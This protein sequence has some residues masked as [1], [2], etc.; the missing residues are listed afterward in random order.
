MQFKPVSRANVTTPMIHFYKGEAD[1]RLQKFIDDGMFNTEVV[2]SAFVDYYDE[3]QVS[4]RAIYVNIGDRD[5]FK[6]HT[7]NIDKVAK[8]IVALFND[9][10]TEI[11]L[12]LS[13]LNSD[14]DAE[15]LIT[16]LA[17]ADYEYDVEFNDNDDKRTIFYVEDV[18]GQFEDVVHR[19]LATANGVN[20]TRYL[21]DLPANICTPTELASIASNELSV[22]KNVK[23]NVLDEVKCRELGMNLLTSVSDGSDEEG[24]VIIVTYDGTDEEEALTLGL[25]GKAVTFD[26]GGISIKPSSKMEEMKYDMCGGATVLGTIRA[27]A[28]AQVP[29]N[30]I[31]IVGAVEN[32]PNG[33]A[34][35]PSSVV[36]GMSGR[37]VEITNTDAEGR[38]VLA[39][40][41]TYIGEIHDCDTVIDL[42]TLT[43]ACCVALGDHA[44]GVFSHD[45]QLAQQLV[46]AGEAV[47][48]RAWR[49]PM[50]E[51]YNKQLK[52]KFA[53]VNN[54]AG[55]GAGASTAACFLGRFAADYDYTHA[56][57]DIA[58]VAWDKMATGRPV[59]LLL[60]YIAEQR[61]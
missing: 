23:V 11:T 58:G 26:S 27:L 39:D 36:T 9:K 19:G 5:E 30:V 15:D 41:L 8:G 47:N 52:S 60:N 49:L 10:C 1:E 21:G 38:L 46:E 16:A 50:W 51:E 57:M 37:T 33:R 14:L 59:K 43:G 31:G 24:K 17:I 55:G 53:D 22:Y 61:V 32:M 42:A 34:T 18:N 4:N 44:A 3:H 25:V 6:A 2:G 45:D 35:K 56:H 40:L 54:S 12:C 13:C 7:G 48:D 28:E 20:F 29:V